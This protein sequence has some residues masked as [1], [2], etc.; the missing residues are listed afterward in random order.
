VLGVRGRGFQWSGEDYILRRFII[1][2]H[3][4]L[5]ES[6]DKIRMTEMGL[7][8]SCMGDEKD[9]YRALVGKLRKMNMGD[10]EIGG[11]TIIKK[12]LKR[13]DGKSWFGFIFPAQGTCT[14][15]L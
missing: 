11:I 9:A 4:I 1:F 14:G 12:I 2:S 6:N 10:R 13:C 7:D 15:L 5:F 3:K 8:C